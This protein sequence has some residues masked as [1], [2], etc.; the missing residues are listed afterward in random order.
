MVRQCAA[1]LPGKVERNLAAI[2]TC[3]ASLIL[4]YPVY[5]D[6]KTGLPYA[7]KEAFKIIRERFAQESSCKKKDS[8]VGILS[9]ATYEP[10]FTQKRKRSVIPQ[11]SETSYFRQ[12]ARFRRIPAVEIEDSD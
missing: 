6:P 8:S 1:C 3:W 12:F 7:T 10:G 4:E 5:R 9:D 11:D 2:W